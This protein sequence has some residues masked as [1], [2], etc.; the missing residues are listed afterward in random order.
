M[1]Q[2]GYTY[3]ESNQNGS[4]KAITMNN[5]S[6]YFGTQSSSPTIVTIKGPSNV[7]PSWKIIQDGQL[8]AEAKYNLT[9]ASSQRLLVSSYPEDQYAR[10]YNADNTYSDV[11]QTA[12]FSKA[13]FV[14]VPLGVSTLLATLDPMAQLEVTFK[15]ERLLV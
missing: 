6:E 1:A 14:Q 4:E 7:P 12:D 3:I 15:Q 13:N 11:T 2:Y 8:I 5:N 10:V 9:L